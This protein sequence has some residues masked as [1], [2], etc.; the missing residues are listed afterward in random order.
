M[1][2]IRNRAWRP[3]VSLFA[4]VSLPAAYGDAF[5]GEE[6]ICKIKGYSYRYRDGAKVEEN[7]HETVE[8]SLV[9]SRYQKRFRINA[10]G[11]F[12]EHK[13]PNILLDT[14]TGNPVEAI[15]L[16]DRID[17]DKFR[18]VTSLVLNKV[19]GDVRGFHHRSIPPNKWRDSDM[20]TGDCRKK[21]PRRMITCCKQLIIPAG[22]MKGGLA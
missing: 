18:T 13:N 7:I 15:Y 11:F 20:Y 12:P 8:F 22:D 10:N 19:S 3:I 6:H 5:F 21:Q 4:A 14:E 9:T 17:Q 1:N 16:S 2:L